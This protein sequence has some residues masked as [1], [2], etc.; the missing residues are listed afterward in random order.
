MAEYIGIYIPDHLRITN[1]IIKAPYRK[2]IKQ[3]TTEGVFVRTFAAV[4]DAAEYM[5][6]SSSAINQCLS[7]KNKT[8][9]GYVW[10]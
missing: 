1:N 9:G 8:A 10:K 3:Y 5:G 4:G 2:K 7:G 6:I